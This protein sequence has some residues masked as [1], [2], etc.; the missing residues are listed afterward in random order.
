MAYKVQRSSKIIEQLELGED[1]T[2]SVVINV[3]KMAADINKAYNDIIRAD[4]AYR[5]ADKSNPEQV[6]EVFGEIG[7]SVLSLFN[8]V[9]GEESAAEVVEYYDEDYLEMIIE[10]LPF[11]SEVIFPQIKKF[12]QEKK[13][14][15]ASNYKFKQKRKFIG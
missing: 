12:S 8:V 14:A 5:K 11:I 2:I 10:V 3:T 13:K 7:K 15:A 9:F 6:L 1:K 4:V